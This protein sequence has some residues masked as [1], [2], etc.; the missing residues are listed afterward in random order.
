MISDEEFVDSLKNTY[1]NNLR[2]KI[3]GSEFDQIQIFYYK[4]HK[5]N[6]NQYIDFPDFLHK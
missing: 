2:T 4:C 1:Q 3:R 5:I 6:L